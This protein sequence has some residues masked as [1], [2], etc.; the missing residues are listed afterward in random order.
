MNWARSKQMSRGGR[1]DTPGS[2]LESRSALLSGPAARLMVLNI[3]DATKLAPNDDLMNVRRFRWNMWGIFV[4]CY[5][6]S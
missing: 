1:P 5:G 3:P 6:Y 4:G 2:N